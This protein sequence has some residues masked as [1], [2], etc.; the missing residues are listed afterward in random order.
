MDERS[1]ST[2]ACYRKLL[3]RCIKIIFEI[4]FETDNI[5]NNKTGNVLTILL[6]ST[7]DTNDH[8]V[9]LG[10]IVCEAHEHISTHI[11]HLF[12]NNHSL[13]LILAHTHGIVY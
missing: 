4:T 6:S 13:L 3:Q 10:G 8:S 5:V 7:D 9:K 11:Y 1:G 2:Y 12:V